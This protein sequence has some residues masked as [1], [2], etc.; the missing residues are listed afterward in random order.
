MTKIITNQILLGI[1]GMQMIFFKSLKFLINQ[2]R[3]FSLLITNSTNFSDENFL[4]HS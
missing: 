4:I 1:N 3:F 2:T